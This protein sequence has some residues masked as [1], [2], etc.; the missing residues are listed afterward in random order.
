[1][2]DRGEIP[3][4]ARTADQVT[5]VATWASPQEI[6]S[7]GQSKKFETAFAPLTQTDR[8]LMATQSAQLS[9]LAAAKILK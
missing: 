8:E 5:A 4:G 2:V 3:R 1:V 9:A 7:P 6:L